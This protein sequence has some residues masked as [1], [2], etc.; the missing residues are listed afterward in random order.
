MDTT[1]KS[2]DI[3]LSFFLL[4]TRSL[5]FHIFIEMNYPFYQ[6]SDEVV[7]LAQ[8]WVDKCL[9]QVKVNDIWYLGT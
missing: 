4:F 6:F 2:H 7:V 5:G 3:L 1:N 9:F 8:V